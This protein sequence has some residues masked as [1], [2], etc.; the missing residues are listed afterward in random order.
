M[1]PHAT[2]ANANA[3]HSTNANR[4][5]SY[6]T[7]NDTHTDSHG[8]RNVLSAV[9]ITN[10]DTSATNPNSHVGCWW[11]SFANARTDVTALYPKSDAIAV[12]NTRAYGDDFG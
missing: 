4:N 8:E 12:T 10:S 5:T 7:D 6:H 3:A 1:R 11:D 9:T 2:F